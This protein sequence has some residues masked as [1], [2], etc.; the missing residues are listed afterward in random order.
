MEIMN[1]SSVEVRN[2]KREE[3]TFPSI[4]KKLPIVITP[5]CDS[6]YTVLKRFVETNRSLLRD[7]VAQSGG[8]LFRGFEIPGPSCFSEVLE[9]MGYELWEKY[10]GGFARRHEV[11]SK[12]FTSSE[13]MDKMPVFAHNEMSYQNIMPAMI[14]FF[15][16][17]E[18]NKL[19]ET[20]IFNCVSIYHNIN[21]EILDL[22]IKRKLKY[23]RRYRKERSV[24][25]WTLSR[26]WNDVFGTD[27]KEFIN[28]LCQTTGTIP[29]WGKNDDL[30]LETNTIPYT[31]HP[32]TGEK[33]LTIQLINQYGVSNDLK[34][35]RKLLGVSPYQIFIVIGSLLAHLM[36]K[37]K[38][39][40]IRVCFGDGECLDKDTSLYLWNLIWRHSVVFK[41]RKNDILVLD[42]IKTAH[43][44]MLVFQPRKILAAVGNA[45]QLPRTVG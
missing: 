43:G 27:D 37:L 17:V 33:C 10:Y 21:R 5:S 4:E 9:L 42:N 28:S 40:Q 18:P 32:V 29:H 34:I 36:F 7:L 16:Q 31:I 25:P 26:V 13:D 44:K 41:W 12:V 14:S 24:M 22:L 1:D 6:H 11:A 30:I 20:P 35:H 38:I 39:A 3:L 45:V 2:L 15:C 8:V 19:S 23:L